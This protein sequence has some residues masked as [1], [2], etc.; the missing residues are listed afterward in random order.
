MGNLTM[1]P[2]SSC[3]SSSCSDCGCDL[4]DVASSGFEFCQNCGCR[5]V[6]EKPSLTSGRRDHEHLNRLEEDLFERVQGLGAEERSAFLAKACGGDERLRRRIDELLAAADSD[7]SILDFPATEYAS[8]S[9]DPTAI[10]SGTTIDNYKLLERIG[11]GGMGT[12]YMAEQVRPIKRIVALKV[13]RAGLDS[14]QVVA[15]FEAERQSLALMDHPNI[16]KVL[17][18]GATEKG[19]PYF[20]MELVKGVALTEYCDENRL[21]PK[22]RVQLIVDVCSAVQH[23]HQ[24]GIIHRDLKPSNI[25][26]A[27]Y[28]DRPVPKVIDFGVAKATHQKLTEKTL[29]TQLGQ[30]VGTLEYMSPEQAVLN[31]LDVDTRSDVYSLGVILY[32][33]LVGETPLDGKELRRQGLEQILRTIREEEPPR[34]SIRISSQGDAATQTAAYRQSDQSTL[35]RTLRGDLDWIVM[36]ALEKDRKRRYDSPSRL[37]EDLFNY[38]HGD[39]V[40]ARPPSFA[41]RSAKMFA[42]NR[43]LVLALSVSFAGLLFGLGTLFVKNDQL[44]DALSKWRQ[45]LVGAGIEAGLRGDVR[46]ATMITEDAKQ[47]EAPEEWIYLIQALAHMH[48]GETDEAT[49]LLSK[50]YEIAPNSM[51]IASVLHM[52]SIGDEGAFVYR[53]PN[54]TTHLMSKLATL[55]PSVEYERYDLLFRGW[56]QVY[57]DPTESVNTLRE[58]VERDQSWPLAQ[59]ML[60]M[61]LAHEASDTGDP[62]IAME[63]LRMIRASERRLTDNLF[64]NF[65]GLACRTEA[66]RLAVDQID[67]AKLISEADDLAEQLRE[68]P[69]GWAADYRAA[70]YEYV[71]HPNTQQ[72]YMEVRN[73]WWYAN[74]AA[75]ML[76]FDSEWLL[77]DL[78]PNP[79]LSPIGTIGES[80]ALA[81]LGREDDARTRFDKLTEIGAWPVKV[82]S[83]EIL[84]HLRDAKAMKECQRRSRELLEDV[85]KQGEEFFDAPFWVFEKR[86]KYLANTP[87]YDKEEFIR[88]MSDSMIGECYANYLIGLKLRANNDL[89]AERYFRDCVSAGQFWMSQYQF[90]KTILEREYAEE[91]E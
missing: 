21:A 70:Y 65:V 58:V 13:I 34:P 52:T 75:V 51:A 20:V 17:D 3:F 24:K 79:T 38:L 78:R 76:R 62:R 27:Q 83:L 18:A 1:K 11:E 37:A 80:C 67:E 63:G 35:S 88:S 45:A 30:I 71:G 36:K 77:Q 68:F 10:V 57:E 82:G 22:E 49:E 33:L 60:A 32:E 14:K 73:D 59:A 12:V 44:T 25:L 53:G 16:A 55:T 9:N 28:D 42:R 85:D 43:T 8:P 69:H 29:Y 81:M 40:G 26:V 47:A 50:A 39:A 72:A 4:D 66:L 84:L 86:L 46:S 90:S 91:A 7:D 48:V 64:V 6:G 54:S 19:E 89:S 5:F 56:S 74:R 23:A 41:Y 61:A 2:G 15:R 87:G 31:Q